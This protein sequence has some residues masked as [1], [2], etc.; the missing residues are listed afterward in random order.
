M[1]IPK[2]L[3]ADITKIYQEK[4]AEKH[5]SISKHAKLF[6]QE[7]FSDLS[8]DDCLVVISGDRIT[9][10]IQNYFVDIHRFKE[11]HDMIGDND[12][13]S[14]GKIAAFTAKW[15]VKM[16]PITIVLS[17]TQTIQCRM[18]A[19][20]IN[21]IFAIEHMSAIL[22]FKSQNNLFKIHKKLQSELIYDFRQKKFSETQ[23]Y[24]LLE[25]ITGFYI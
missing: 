11:R 24:M 23:L 14:N 10:I 4:I 9:E 2:K 6:T 12:W 21:E 18:L 8:E 25:H 13:T 7:Y 17:G 19:N 3:L 5:E 22:N 15:L 16:K 1:G 20:Y